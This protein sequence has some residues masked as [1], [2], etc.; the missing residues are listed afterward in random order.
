[1]PA[2]GRVQ[3][4]SHARRLAEPNS[5]GKATSMG[6][7]RPCPWRL[8]QGRLAWPSRGMPGG[9]LRSSLVQTSTT[10]NSRSTGPT[11]LQE[12]FKL[13]RFFYL[14][15]GARC[16]GWSTPGPRTRAVAQVVSPLIYGRSG[17]RDPAA[18]RHACPGTPVPCRHGVAHFSCTG[19]PPQQNR[20]GEVLT[21]GMGYHDANRDGSRANS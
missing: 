13:A 17:G 7:R 14:G 16:T 2:P 4:D 10:A 20:K 12:R 11:L 15:P 8:A 1:M 18:W 6:Q 9:W 21:M 19:S 5:R 3:F